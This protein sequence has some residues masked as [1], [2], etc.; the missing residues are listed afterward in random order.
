MADALKQQ[1]GMDLPEDAKATVQN[2]KCGKTQTKYLNNQEAVE[3]RMF[4][5]IQKY[6]GDTLKP[7]LEIVTCQHPTRKEVHDYAFYNHLKGLKTLAK[8]KILNQGFTTCALTWKSKNFGGKKSLQPNSFIH[9]MKLLSYIFWQKG[10]LYQFDKDFNVRGKF[11]GVAIDYWHKIHKDDPTFG[12]GVNVA[13][14][15]QD[16]DKHTHQIILEGKLK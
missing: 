12:M 10:I 5:T 1:G 15:V 8:H 14:F 13:E 4:N 9:Y 3:C 16:Y 2:C 7:L 11:H 6:G